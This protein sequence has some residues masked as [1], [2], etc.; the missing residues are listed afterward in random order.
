MAVFKGK[1]IM[2]PS[3]STMTSFPRV[4]DGGR[5]SWTECK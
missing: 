1:Q 4:D 5:R 3:L 2:S